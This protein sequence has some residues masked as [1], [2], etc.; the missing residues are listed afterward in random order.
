MWKYI[1][2][3]RTDSGTGFPGIVYNKTIK[4]EKEKND[5]A[6]TGVFV[7]GDV[8]VEI[9]TDGATGSTFAPIAEM[10]EYTLSIDGG[11]ESWH[12]YGGGAWAKKLLTSKD[13]KIEAK[14]K[15]SLGDAGNDYVAGLFLKE[16]RDVESKIKMTFP[17]GSTITAPVLINVTSLGVGGAT[18]VGP[19][20]FTAEFNGKPEYKAGTGA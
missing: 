16:G 13:G 6:F 11:V 15:R 2:R 20:E 10:E 17:D 7:S 12:P 18:N 5:M 3:G 8:D 4:Q 19:L 9:A 14:G 1:I